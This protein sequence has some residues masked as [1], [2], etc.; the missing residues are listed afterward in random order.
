MFQALASTPS[1]QGT[2]ATQTQHAANAKLLWTLMQK[3]LRKSPSFT[4]DTYLVASAVAALSRGNAA[5]IELAFTIVREYHGLG[6]PGDPPWKGS[7]P[8]SQQSLDIILKLCNTSKKHALC[9]HF[10]Q[11]VKRQPDA[12]GGVHLLDH[13]HLNEVLKARIASPDGGVAYSCLETLEWM[14]H[15]EIVGRN[16][17]K[18]RPNMLTYNLVLTAC[19]RDGDWRSAARVFDL[20][21]GY[22]SHDFMDGSVSRSPRRDERGV[23]RN[24][25]PPAETLSSLVRTALASRDRAN[26]RQCLRI[27][28]FLEVDR[29]LAMDKVDFN[30]GAKAKVFFISKLASAIVEAVQYV[31]GTPSKAHSSLEIGRWKQLENIAAL[32]ERRAQARKSDFTPTLVME[33]PREE[34]AELT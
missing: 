1:G 2:T 22:H 21:T 17:F 31:L 29:L 25:D 15:Q 34:Q 3:A 11:Q 14:L 16:G 5:E 19:W 18:I 30:K 6:A 20:M 27:L 12:L 26:I 10:F 32:N 9:A 33:R 4:V 7:I 23:G 8:L 24:L 28:D 13:G